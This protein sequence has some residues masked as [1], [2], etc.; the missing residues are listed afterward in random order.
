MTAVLSE[1]VLEKIFNIGTDEVPLHLL[2]FPHHSGSEI[3]N[4]LNILAER[5][6]VYRGNNMVRLTGKGK[7][8]AAQVARKHAVLETFLKDVLGKQPDAAS[9]EACILEHNIS[10]ET[11]ERL[12]NFLDQR[13]PEPVPSETT[14]FINHNNLT[15]R[16]PIVPLSECPE[17]SLLHVSMIRCF[18]KHNRLIDLGVI[19]GELITLRRKLVNNAV[20]ITVKGCDIALSPEVSANIMVER[21]ETP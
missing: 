17:G 18:A 12:D 8:K 14:G 7:E 19:P 5:G 2:T 9:K 11:I 3:E 21:C 6:F 16:N 10:S 20:V 4:V 15:R 1:D 13:K